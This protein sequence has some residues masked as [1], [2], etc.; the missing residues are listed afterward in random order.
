MGR[1]GVLFVKMHS[2]LAVF[3]GISVIESIYIIDIQPHKEACVL[4]RYFTLC[5]G[6]DML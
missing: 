3:N 5:K 4:N 2:C 1:R 6:D